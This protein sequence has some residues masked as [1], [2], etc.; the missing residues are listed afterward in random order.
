M[1]PE[2]DLAAIREYC[3][4]RVPQEAHDQV[5]IETQ[6]AQ[7]AVTVIERRPPWHDAD[8]GG[9]WIEHPVARLRSAAKSGLWTLYWHDS[10]ER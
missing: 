2:L 3:E 9:D 7:N 4:Q 8:A 1:V 10:N 5:R 6:V